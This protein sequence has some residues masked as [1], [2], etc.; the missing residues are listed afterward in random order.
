MHAARRF[1][2]RTLDIQVV[3]TAAINTM[4]YHHSYIPAARHTCVRSSRQYEDARYTV[5][6][7]TIRYTAISRIIYLRGAH[8]REVCACLCHYVAQA[9]KTPV[10]LRCLA[11]I[12]AL[13]VTQLPSL[14]PKP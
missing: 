8:V 4:Y 1:R 13:E 10:H 7:T 5:V 11:A 14:N 3:Y 12:R 2:M 6:Y 9:F